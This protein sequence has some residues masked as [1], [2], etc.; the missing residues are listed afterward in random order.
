M[1]VLLLAVGYTA[2]PLSHYNPLSLSLCIPLA[3]RRNIL[4][5]NCTFCIAKCP[6]CWERTAAAGV[7][8]EISNCSG[9]MCAGMSP[10]TLEQ[11]KFIVN[12]TQLCFTDFDLH[13]ILIIFHKIFLSRSDSFDKWKEH[14][15]IDLKWE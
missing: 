14:M 1:K 8:L 4:R 13:R 7:R 5:I 15:I 6:P 10:N 2:D 9:F 3:S 11:R 12:S